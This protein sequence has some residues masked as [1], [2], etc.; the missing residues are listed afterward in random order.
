[1]EKV[2][3]LQNNIWKTQEIVEKRNELKNLKE[4]F[5]IET[6]PISNSLKDEK[7]FKKLHK[8]LDES[9]KFHKIDTFDEILR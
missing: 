8:Y 5:E 9:L 7:E 2:K 3:S 4:E 1:M 6:E